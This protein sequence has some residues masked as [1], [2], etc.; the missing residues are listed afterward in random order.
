[1]VK[2]LA[3]N[4]VRKVADHFEK[5]RVVLYMRQQQQAQGGDGEASTSS[6]HK[7]LISPHL[8]SEVRFY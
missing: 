5:I 7:F 4:V 1:M 3:N 8:V 6:A 2:L